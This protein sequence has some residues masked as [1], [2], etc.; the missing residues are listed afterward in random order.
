MSLEFLIETDLETLQ[1]MLG[2]GPRTPRKSWG[3]RNHFESADHTIESIRRLVA[4]GLVEGREPLFRATYVGA[5]FAG[6]DRKKAWSVSHPSGK[7]GA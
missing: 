6:L 4:C 1:H 5:L 3:Y 7:S 2:V